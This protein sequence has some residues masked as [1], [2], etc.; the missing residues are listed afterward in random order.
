MLFYYIKNVFS[1]IFVLKHVTKCRTD[2]K[3]FWLML[4][5]ETRV[6]TPFTIVSSL[7]ILIA[8]FFSIFFLCLFDFHLLRFDVKLNFWLY[9]KTFRKSYCIWLYWHIRS[10]KTLWCQWCLR[11]LFH[12]QC[13]LNALLYFF[14]ILS[15]YL[16]KVTTMKSRSNIQKLLYLFV[17]I[18]T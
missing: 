7:A 9:V 11:R 5:H 2:M 16:K 18:L 14:V 3:R 15:V 4:I 1:F 13:I 12:F 17:C 6:Y 8:V 10:H